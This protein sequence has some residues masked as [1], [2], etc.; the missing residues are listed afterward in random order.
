MAHLL[1][2]VLV[3]VPAPVLR[4]RF[5]ETARVLMAVVEAA[6]GNVRFFFFFFFFSFPAPFFPTSLSHYPAAHLSHP[7]SPPPSAT[8][9]PA[10]PP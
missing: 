8:P 7:S 3:R 5:S 9:P 2:L 6:N 4:T 10:W 1:D